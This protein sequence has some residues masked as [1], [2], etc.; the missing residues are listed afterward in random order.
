MGFQVEGLHRLIPIETCSIAREEICRELGRIREEAMAKLPA[1]YPLANLVA[2]GLYA[3]CAS[4]LLRSRRVVLKHR[5][6]DPKLALASFSHN[7]RWVSSCSRRYVY[8][9]CGKA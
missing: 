1:D 3:T 5:V 2:R 4:G 7:P 6:Q 9:Q 8:S